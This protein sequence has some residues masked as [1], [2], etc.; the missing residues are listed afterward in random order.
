LI[1]TQH[2][3]LAVLDPDESAVRDGEARREMT[4]TCG[5]GNSSPALAVDAHGIARSGV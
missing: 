2:D 4:D 5:H 1:E 3:V